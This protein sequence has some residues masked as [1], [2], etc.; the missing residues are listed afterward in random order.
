[1]TGENGPIECQKNQE[2]NEREQQL[3]TK[4]I[5]IEIVFG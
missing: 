4:N 2:R 5:Y 3:H 1:M